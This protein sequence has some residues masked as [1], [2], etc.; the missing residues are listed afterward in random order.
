MIVLVAFCIVGLCIA[1][2]YAARRAAAASVAEAR[3]T[4]LQ[5][6]EGVWSEKE[7]ELRELQIEM[8]GRDEQL[9]A[10]QRVV[11][12]RERELDLMRKEQ[13]KDR[14]T[15]T[16]QAGELKL[17]QKAIR[18]FQEKQDEVARST[19]EAA[20]SNQR[21]ETTLLDWTRQIASPQ[22]RGAFGELALR[23]Q[24]TAL[25]LEEGRDF[26]RQARP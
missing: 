23:N 12:D 13:S 22:G 7:I 15:V 8:R 9:A 2:A 20:G 26:E 14:E 11:E 25:G 17:L 4:A 6:R 24:L 21:I 16:E 1:I 18:E 10:E 19:L 3:L 5:E